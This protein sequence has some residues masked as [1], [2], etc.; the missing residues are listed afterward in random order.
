MTPDE[1]K[2]LQQLYSAL[3]VVSQ[4]ESLVGTL[5]DGWKVN[6]GSDLAHDDAALPS[7]HLSPAAWSSIS[8]AVSHLGCL[9]D[10]L[11][12]D[13][14]PN[15]VHARIHTH[16]QMTLLR[17]AL[18]NASM[19]IWLLQSDDRVERV[20]RRL[21]QDWDEAIQQESVREF[22]GQPRNK[23]EE[24]RL[25]E[26]SNIATSAGADAAK[27]KKRPGY[28]AIVKLAGEHHPAGR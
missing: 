13:T 19:S 2:L 11:F 24:Q 22:M 7:H 18:E 21:Q 17:G 4:W 14:G 9:R 1:D 5:S 27:I 12:Q 25:Q 28:G 20:L 8:A 16:G 26:L 15:N 6:P 3:R 23:T 10:S